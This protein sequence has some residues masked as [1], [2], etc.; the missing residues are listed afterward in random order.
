MKIFLIIFSSIVLT[1]VGKS[2]WA[3]AHTNPIKC[4]FSQSL[5]NKTQYLN[6]IEE[7]EISE[8]LHEKQDQ[9]SSVLP[10]RAVSATYY[11]SET[12][13]RISLSDKFASIKS[14]FLALFKQH[15]NYRI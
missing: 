15:G 5:S 12:P 4:K 1:F 13:I 11:A 9:V 3:H 7:E 8:D 2:A 14:H 6:A 10:I